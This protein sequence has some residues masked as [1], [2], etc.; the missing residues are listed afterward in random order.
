MIRSSVKA[1]LGSI[2]LNHNGAIGGYHELA[3][4][5]Y[6]TLYH[7]HSYRFQSARAAFQVLLRNIKP[8][9]V[10]IPKYTCD[11]IIE[12]LQ[13]EGI[14]YA[15]YDLDFDLGIKNNISLK[16]D[17]YILYVNYFGLCDKQ[18]ER[19]LSLVSPSRVILDFSQAFFNK[20]W[21]KALATIYSPRKFFGV[22]DGGFLET[23]VSIHLPNQQDVDSLERMDYL[24]KRLCMEPENGYMDYQHAEFS[25]SNLEPK[26][27]SRLTERLLQ[28]I[29]FEK[30]KKG[31]CNNFIFLEESLRKYNY[32]DFS[33]SQN[34][35]PLCYPFM[36]TDNGLKEYLIKHRVF[37]P[38]YWHDAID[39]VGHE[40]AGKMIHNLLPLPIDHRYGIQE[41]TRIS[42]LVVEGLGE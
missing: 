8:K 39:R 40:W 29:D 23:K 25:L 41:M 6:G 28:S 20:K 27:M 26:K 36:T 22:P 33:V 35:S 19:L 37:V 14:R 10:W 34:I 12:P 42:K 16:D 30:V 3:L 31:R 21:P 13:N 17:E 32:F 1:F 5:Q 2:R 11:A 9:L 4:P 38:T 24:L 15:W 18:V 7:D